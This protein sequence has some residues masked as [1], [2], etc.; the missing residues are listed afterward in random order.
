METYHM[1]PQ[2]PYHWKDCLAWSLRR[3]LAD[4]R[5]LHNELNCQ[6]QPDDCEIDME[7]IQLLRISVPVIT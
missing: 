7:E 1:V 5:Y 2:A 3:Q 4:L 6:N